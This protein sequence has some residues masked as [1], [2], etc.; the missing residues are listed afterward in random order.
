MTEANRSDPVSWLLLERY[1]LGEVTPAEAAVVERALAADP[2]TRACFE[3]MKEPVR[4]RPLPLQPA[5]PPAHVVALRRVRRALSSP[6]S[7]AV[8]AVAAV[9][10][11]YFGVVGRKPDDAEL[12]SA[13]VR[14][15]GGDRS[16]AL[17]RDRDGTVTMDPK[18]F[19]AGDRFKVLFTCPP[20]SDERVQVYVLQGKEA[21]TPLALPDPIPCGNGVPLPGA[22]SLTGSVPSTVCVAWGDA[23]RRPDAVR[24]APAAALRGSA[25]CT[26]LTPGP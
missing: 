18:S 23:A 13:M 19:E 17:V 1:A 7:A 22:F 2:D 25:V 14:I 20:G 8:L 6:W 24:R 4:L 16:I 26:E 21:S 10:A 3:S 15:K 12:P 5:A 11:L 9:F